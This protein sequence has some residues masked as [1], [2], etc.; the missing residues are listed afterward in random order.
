MK[1]PIVFLSSDM[2]CSPWKWK[3]ENQ[4][5]NRQKSTSHLKI[6]KNSSHNKLYK[7]DIEK[8]KNWKTKNIRKFNNSKTRI[9][10]FNFTKNIKELSWMFHGVMP[11]WFL[12]NFLFILVFSDI[13]T[14]LSISCVFSSGFSDRWKSSCLDIPRPVIQFDYIN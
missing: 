12:L 7:K 9:S 5:S 14:S 4:K 10:F 1:L 3:S 11:F 6:N 2:K 13:L 8:G